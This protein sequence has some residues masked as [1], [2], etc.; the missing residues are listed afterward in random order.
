MSVTPIFTQEEKNKL[1]HIEK[2]ALFKDSNRLRINVISYKKHNSTLAHKKSEI[3]ETKSIIKAIGKLQEKYNITNDTTLP[4]LPAKLSKTMKTES[5]HTKIKNHR[6]SMHQEE[7]LNNDIAVNKD[8]LLRYKD[9][10]KIELLKQ[11]LVE[12]K[13]LKEAEEQELLKHQLLEETILKEAEEVELSKRKLQKEVE[14]ELLKH[15]LEE[16]VLKEVEAIEVEKVMITPRELPFC[17]FYAT[18]GGPVHSEDERKE[19]EDDNTWEN[20]INQEEGKERIV[21]VKNKEIRYDRLVKTMQAR[22][23]V[24][25]NAVKTHSEPSEVIKRVENESVYSLDIIVQGIF[26]DRIQ[27]E[28]Y[29]AIFKAHEFDCESFVMLDKTVLTELGI[30]SVGAQLK[31]LKYVKY[32]SKIIIY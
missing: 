24:P 9:G 12:K 25:R 30:M 15:K 31:I 3:K 1:Y 14:E 4:D 7:T 17:P 27:Y 6:K 10:D 18:P 28:K 23:D 29:Y 22:T 13:L 19:A 2:E 8:L 32:L 16:K 5:V 20:E 26:S 21:V 11:K